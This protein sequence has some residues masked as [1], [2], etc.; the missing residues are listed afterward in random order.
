ML[1]ICS[2]KATCNLAMRAGSRE[3][4]QASPDDRKADW[5]K[6]ELEDGRKFAQAS[7]GA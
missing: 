3:Q 2:M 5:E 4:S 7:V 1:S 6:P